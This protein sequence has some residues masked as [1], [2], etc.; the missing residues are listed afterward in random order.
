MHE[1]KYTLPNGNTI[2][3]FT[4]GDKSKQPLF[5]LH[6]IGLRAKTYVPLYEKLADHYYIIAPDMPGFGKSDMPEGKFTIDNIAQAL[7]PFLNETL[8]QPAILSGHS[9]GGAV[10]MQ[11][12]ANTPQ[13]FT[14]LELFNPIIPPTRFTIIGSLRS[15]LK[16]T[17]WQGSKYPHKRILA[18]EG[19]LV[20]WWFAKAFF[21]SR[22][23]F[24]LND[25]LDQPVQI[26]IEPQHTVTIH[27]GKHDFLLDIDQIYENL[28]MQT[29]SHKN[30]IFKEYDAGHGWCW[31]EPELLESLR[32]SYAS[33][34]KVVLPNKLT[35][36]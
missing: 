7:L 11:L 3:Y 24:I 25:S 8:Q 6:G 9:L 31:L 18:H 35:F 36:S 17:R 16:Q 5:F 30:L 2:T 27:W 14:Q 32:V 22:K 10:A 12:Y 21:T 4:H 26:C 1:H 29:D 15:I 19:A 20:V 23:L 28:Q 33:T 34:G 13:L